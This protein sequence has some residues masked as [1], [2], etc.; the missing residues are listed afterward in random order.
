MKTKKKRREFRTHDFLVLEKRV[1]ILSMVLLLDK[2]GLK[3]WRYG[4]RVG[5]ASG[6]EIKVSRE[7]RVC[8]RV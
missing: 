7:P 3:D 1:G 6:V 8:S 4:D 2:T 5:L